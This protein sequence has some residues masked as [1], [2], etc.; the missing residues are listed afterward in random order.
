LT[1][2]DPDIEE[3]LGKADT[4]DPASTATKMVRKASTQIERITLS[5][6]KMSINYFN[7]ANWQ[8]RQAFRYA[9]FLGFISVGLLAFFIVAAVFAA[10]LHLYG[11]AVLLGAIGGVGTTI[12]TVMG[13]I[14]SSHAK[15][16]EQF[17]VAQKLLDRSY[18]PT[19][20]NA[21]CIGYTDEERKQAALDNIIG[22]LL[23]NE[24]S[25][26]DVN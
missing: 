20:A 12:G 18:R 7:S 15:T 9:W 16:A 26:I 17:A 25:D 5:H 10:L 6:Q 8:S 1:L 22:G 23:K 14:S 13:L 3:D 11:F 2:F 21:M 24:A 4:A 19:I